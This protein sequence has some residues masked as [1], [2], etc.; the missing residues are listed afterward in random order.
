MTTTALPSQC[1]LVPM[2]LSSEDHFAELERQRI[3][4]G[5]YKDQQTLQN[6]KRKQQEGLKNLFWITVPDLQTPDGVP[7]HVGH[8][9]LDA[10]CDPPE[11]DLAR[12]D[13]SRLAISTFFILPEYRSLRLGRQAVR[14]IEQMA[15]VEPYGSS[16]CE[17]IALMAQ[18]KRHI[19][20]EGP[21]WK[22]VWARLGMS[23]PAFS[24]QEWYEKL[25]Y[26]TWKEGPLYKETALDG[27]VIDLWEALMQKDLKSGIPS[28]GG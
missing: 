27:Q 11:L 14:L 21:E 18:S 17:F 23:P 2:D 3:I 22:G 12:P 24:I 7:I 19:Y 25:G 15:V 16:R 6:W 1:H 13:K 10:Y 20:D 9:S 26:V 28:T 8:I 5:W 4:C